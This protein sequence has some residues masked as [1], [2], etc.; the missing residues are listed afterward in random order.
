MSEPIYFYDI[1]NVALVV[2]LIAVV[3]YRY[4]L[5]FAIV[6]V[7]LLHFS[8]IFLTNNVLFDPNYMP[9]Q[10][11]YLRVAQALRGSGETVSEAMW[12]L[13]VGSAGV[14]FGLFPIPI[15]NSIYSIAIINF[16]LYLLVFLFLYERGMLEGLSLWIFLLYPS[17]L[18]YTSVSLRDTMV[19]VL[20]VFSFWLFLRGRVLL[21]VLV[22]LPLI[23]L[24][25]QNIAI[26]GLSLLIFYLLSIF[27][28]KMARRR[29]PPGIAYVFLGAVILATPFIYRFAFP[30]LNYYRHWMWTE[31]T[32]IL[33]A[34]IPETQIS[35]LGALVMETFKS[36]PYYLLKPLPWE[37]KNTFQLI[38]SAENLLIGALVVVLIWRAYRNRARSPEMDF[39]LLYFVVSLAV[40]GLVI[41][42]FGTA[43]RYKFPYVALFLTFYSRFYDVESEKR[44]YITAEAGV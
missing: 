6:L 27:F 1:I 19:F 20:M 16:I 36:I 9:D 28:P 4:R 22:Q 34:P 14:V 8:L 37:A 24:K 31:D 42:N 26:Y 29:I 39:L 10:F 5:R 30:W 17:M 7:L 13:A 35:G 11:K 25:F 41:W 21:S 33:I 15:I 40:Y 2:A 44:L 32:G 12:N 38:Q 3:Q 43:V 23:I 18:L